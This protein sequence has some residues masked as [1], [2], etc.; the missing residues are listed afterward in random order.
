MG[1]TKR[2]DSYYVEFRVVDDGQV[3]RL[4]AN[5]AGAKLKRWKVGSLNKTMAKQQ[6]TLIKTDLMKGLVRSDRVQAPFTFKAL[7]ESY[8]T[9]P[10]V[11]SQALYHWK[12]CIVRRR[13][14]PVFG[15]RLIQA[16]TPGMIEQYRAA[17]LA[18]GHKG[19]PLR[20]ATL[21]R[22]MALLKHM[23]AHAVREQ[24]LDRNPVSLVKFDKEHNV[25]DRVLTPEEY[26]RLQACAAP[27]LQFINATAYHTAMRRGEILGLTWDRVDLS[28]GLVTLRPEDTKTDEGRVV[29]LTP[30]LTDQLRDLYKV[31]FLHEPH[32]FLVDGKPVKSIKTAFKAAC[33]RAGIQG[34][35]FHDFRHT[36][37]TN[38][39]RAGLDHLTIMKITG[40]KTLDVF[41]RYNTFVAEDLRAAAR[42]LNTYITLQGNPQEGEKPKS[43]INQ[44]KRP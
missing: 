44:P 18:E 13:L 33:R 36:A 14:I 7:A 31:R 32:V 12:V 42:Q 5:M 40:H 21:N 16:I 26:E 24:W 8:L 3:L 35:R 25:R 10:E 6:E 19:R 2:S 30:D 9:G 28:T 29:P 43:A 4:A 39:R 15:T 34:F 17:R 23:F 1:L 22:Y 27:H 41:K 38:M 37:V 11:T 20:F